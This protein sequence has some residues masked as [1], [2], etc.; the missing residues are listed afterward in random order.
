MTRRKP[1][2]PSRTNRSNDHVLRMARAVFTLPST[3][4]RWASDAAV[5]RMTRSDE[6][7]R[8]ADQLRQTRARRHLRGLSADHD[9]ATDATRAAAGRARGPAKTESV[10]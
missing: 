8:S 9:P 2:A 10:P 6:A 7:L 5:V 3:I 4:V 1:V